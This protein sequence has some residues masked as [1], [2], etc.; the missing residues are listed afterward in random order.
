MARNDMAGILDAETAFNRGFKEIAELGSNRENSAQEQ[1]RAGLAEPQRGKAAGDHKAR[2]KP[3]HGSGPRLLR[4]D[5][6]PEFRS[7]NT[8]AREITA[9]IG[10]PYDQ[11]DKDER[12]KSHLW[13]EAHHH[14]CNLRRGGIAKSGRSPV[15]LSW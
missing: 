15:P 13:I 14:R 5:P 2:Q 6:G 4:T 7:A 8:A 3:A 1:Q 10:H 9:D 11:E 12:H